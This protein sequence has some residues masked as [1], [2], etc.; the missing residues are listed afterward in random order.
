[1]RFFISYY[2][3]LKP[4]ELQITID[5][6]VAGQAGLLGRPPVVVRPAALTVGPV[7]VVSA[8]DAVPPTAGAAVL[9][10]VKDAAVRPP[11]AV[12]LCGPTEEEEDKIR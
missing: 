10:H 12:A 4:S 5:V 2:Q 11:A 3:S 9:L 7:R 6:A 8:A 1:M